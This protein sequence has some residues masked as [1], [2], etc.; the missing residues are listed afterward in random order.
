MIAIPDFVRKLV[1]LPKRVPEN[2]RRY[3]E[4]APGRAREMVERLDSSLIGEIP[5][6]LFGGG[7]AGY[8]ISPAGLSSSSL[9]YSFGVGND[10][11]FELAIA[12]AFDLSIWAHDPTDESAKFLDSISLPNKFFYK[13]VGVGAKDGDRAIHTLKASSQYRAAT[14]LDVQDTSQGEDVMP[15]VSFR[16]LLK[17]NGHEHIDLIKMDVEGAEYEFLESLNGEDMVFNQIA[18]EFHPHLANQAIGADICDMKGWERTE[19]AIK[20]LTDNGFK[21]I[22]LSDRGTEFCFVRPEA[23]T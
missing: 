6:Q 2:I 19:A 7:S 9:L 17:A 20:K 22:E 15:I 13:K 11:S 16:T 1:G 21:I 10:I 8:N 23:V 4:L 5:L 3:Y 12:E 18:M 14:I